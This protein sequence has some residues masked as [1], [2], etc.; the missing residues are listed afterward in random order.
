MKSFIRKL[1]NKFTL[2]TPQV[3][4]G[5]KNNFDFEDRPE[6][7]RS[8]GKLNEDKT[9]YVIKR[10]PGTGMFSNVTF[11]LNHLRIC[12]KKGYIPIV[13]MQNFKT[14]YN[15]HIETR[16]TLNSWEYYFE[17]LNKFS[18]DEVYQSKNV[19]LT[20]NK[21]YHYFTYNI[22]KDQILCNFLQSEIKLKKHI[23]KS[24][25]KIISKFEGKK[26]LGIH[27]RGTSYKRSAGHPLP[28]TKRQMLNITNKLLREEKIDKIFLVTEEKNYLDFYLKHFGDKLIYLKS[29]YRSN[30]NDAFKI[31]P[32][33]F[34]RYK[35]GREAVIETFALSNC[36]YF[37]YLCSNVSSAAIALNLKTNQKRYEVDNGFNSKNIIFSQ[38]YWYIKKILPI[39]FGGF[40]S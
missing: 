27:F 20:S 14:I 17:Q 34:H 24:Y 4:E 31:Y 30:K 37:V 9:F 36:D 11:V 29:C 7:I 23:L 13:D 3:L 12:K 10:S 21:F 2:Q 16:N 38:F 33:N 39:S 28:A 19:I 15:E 22:D 26:V 1:I 8:F 25:N 6:E 40:K 5:L 35:M 18:L 32:R